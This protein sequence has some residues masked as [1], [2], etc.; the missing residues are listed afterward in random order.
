MA[1]MH[2]RSRTA[3]KGQYALILALAMAGAALSVGCRGQTSTDAPIVPLRNMYDQPRYDAQSESSFFEDKRTMRPPVTGAV[4]REEVL[5]PRVATGRTPGD[6][7]YM[8]SIPEP[9]VSHLG[10]MEQLLARG[11]E[12]YGIYCTP[13][14]DSTGSG[15]GMVVRRGMLPPP[16]FH[17]DRLRH[18]P[19]GQVF[20]TI[21]N[22]IRNMPAYAAQ[23]PVH[24]RWA[25][26]GY[27]R[28]LQLSQLPDNPTQAAAAPVEVEDET[29]GAN[30]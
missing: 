10:G 23:I 20:A 1:A 13:C 21:S 27:V 22:G 19:D 15:Q 14:H 7:A 9:A 29:N 4:A 26:V 2:Q 12:R 30:Q 17:S 16:S 24:D 18:L 6:D 25:I 5:D 11:Q 8:L 28:A 3:S